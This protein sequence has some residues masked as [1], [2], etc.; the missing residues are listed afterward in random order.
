MKATD[1]ERG[2][3]GWLQDTTYQEL[4]VSP[5]DLPLTVIGPD[6]KLY[7]VRDWDYDENFVNLTCD[8]PPMGD[9]T[10]AFSERSGEG[11]QNDKLVEYGTM[12]G[13]RV[14]VD[15]H[16]DQ[17]YHGQSNCAF[18]VWGPD[19]GWLETARVG[20]GFISKR[21]KELTVKKRSMCDANS[22]FQEN[23]PVDEVKDELVKRAA[24]V[25]A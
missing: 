2:T 6:G 7:P 12:M 13:Y 9:L 3:L 19:G 10:V 14:K 24:F 17:S 22:C 5:A 1:C 23:V 16:I 18:Y 20:V 21:A 11:S 15:I 25:L 4:G 8:W